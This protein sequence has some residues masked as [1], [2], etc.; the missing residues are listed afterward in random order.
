MANSGAS[1]PVRAW[2]WTI[3]AMVLAMVLVGGITRL[4]GSGLSMVEW[5]P[6]MGVLPP[7][8]D[9][10]WLEVFDKYKASPQYQQV[11]HWMQLEDFKRIFFWEYVHRLLGRLLGAVVFVPWVFFVLRGALSR[12]LALRTALAFLLGGAQG[13]MGWYMVMSGLAQRPEVSHFRLA[14]HL[15]LAFAVG[16]WVLWIVLDEATPR[17]ADGGARRG[18]RRAVVAFIALI[19]LQSIYGAFMAGTRAGFAYG[20]FPDMH[21]HFLPGPFFSGSLLEDAL[22]SPSAIHYIHRLLGWLC[23]FFGLGLWAYLRKAEPS[24]GVR[25]GAGLV[26]LLVFAQLNLGALTVVTRVQLGWAVAHQG[27]AY[28][29]LSASV[30]LLHRALGGAPREQAVG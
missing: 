15:T 22:H 30:S 24:A 3:W 17:R 14:A 5:R 4:S 8:S 12:R 6:L 9:A 10:Q 28:L 29:L 1:R 7:T 20:T 25:R 11:N 23:F 16:Q 18:H 19:V 2:L 21:G 13:L 26:A 27:L